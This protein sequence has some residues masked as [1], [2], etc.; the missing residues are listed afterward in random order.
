[1]SNAPFF[2]VGKINEIETKKQRGKLFKHNL[3][4]QLAIQVV[5]G[6]NRHLCFNFQAKKS[7]LQWNIDDKFEV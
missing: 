6:K 7:N 2:P 4:I 5:I 1:L 3:I